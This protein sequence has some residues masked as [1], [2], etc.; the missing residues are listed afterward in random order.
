[1]PRTTWG[2]SPVDS[3]CPTLGPQ[4]RYGV[5]LERIQRD[6]KGEEFVETIWESDT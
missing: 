3:T 2:G 4:G 5:D 6:E 1:V